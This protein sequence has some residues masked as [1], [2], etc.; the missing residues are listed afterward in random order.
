MCEIGLDSKN[1]N[2]AYE[3]FK[4]SIL[5]LF[6][7]KQ[8]TDPNDVNALRDFRKKLCIISEYLKTPGCFV[9]HIRY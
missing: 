2:Y 6:I 7:S 8:N 5:I 9:G 4:N 3:H 1:I